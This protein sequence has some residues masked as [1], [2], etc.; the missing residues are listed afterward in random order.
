MLI[1]RYA[2]YGQV[3]RATGGVR[4]FRFT[5]SLKRVE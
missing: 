1:I 5:L 3:F 2:D 4:G